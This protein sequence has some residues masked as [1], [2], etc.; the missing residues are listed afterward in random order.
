MRDQVTRRREELA[1]E[2]ESGR[3]MLAQLDA[4]RAELETTLL[5]ISGALQVLDELLS[6]QPGTAAAEPVRAAEL[7]GGTAA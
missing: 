5:R 3:E 6:D 7:V 1:A 2:L 4:R